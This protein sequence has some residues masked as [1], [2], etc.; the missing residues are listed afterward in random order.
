MLQVT[1]WMNYPSFF[2]SDLF[3]EL[4]ASGEV[5]L[6][7]IYA[8][9]L[10][11]DRLQLGWREDI[12]GHS[13][14]FISRWNPLADAV[15][16][17]WSQRER[18]HI[19]NGM[20]A[21]P[22]FAAA[23][24]ALAIAKCS[25][26]IYSEA[27]DPTVRRSMAKRLLRTGF[28]RALSSKV[29]GVLAVSHLAFEFYLGLGIPE[30]VMYPFGYFRSQVHP[31]D[32]E[33]N[34]K[35]EDRIE[36]VFAGQLIPRKGIDLLLDAL[37]DLFES[38]PGLILTLIGGG[39]LLPSLRRR[40]E[41]LGL[42]N[43]VLFEGVIGP[44]KIPSRIAAAD[45]LVLPSRWDGWGVVINEAFSVGTPVIASD[46]CG[47]A[48]L[49]RNGENGYIF[50]SENVE[51]LRACLSSFLSRRTEWSSFRSMSTEVGNKITT[52]EAAAYLINCLKHISG[53]LTERPVPPWARIGV[54]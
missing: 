47:G 43:R 26:V 36:I 34:L 2:Q 37:Q 8:R 3:K 17:A 5:D 18:I 48:D 13:Y 31:K 46:R 32:R 29:A 41:T 27:P 10:I 11:P 52:R 54:S 4:I 6:Q 21:E 30:N 39:E 40:V 53:D 25:F 16:L 22:S 24:V 35:N 12:K 42:E 49:I 20:W 23:L 38:Y 50:R 45:L 7:V 14:R 15:R 9:P 44:D 28:G 51:D 33:R 1:I 19:V